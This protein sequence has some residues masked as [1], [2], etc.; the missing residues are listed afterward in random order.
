[1]F[2]LLSVS[3]MSCIFFLKND[4]LILAIHVQGS[5]RAN[6]GLEAELGDRISEGDAESHGH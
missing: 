5:Q 6:L 2:S 4:L 1:M 3:K